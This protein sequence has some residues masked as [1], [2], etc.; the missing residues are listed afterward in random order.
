MPGSP[1][2]IE[3][4]SQDGW[5]CGREGEDDGVLQTPEVGRSRERGGGRKRTYCPARYG[6]GNS[7]TSQKGFCCRP[8]PCAAVASEQPPFPQ[9]AYGSHAAENAQVPVLALAEKGVGYTT[10]PYSP[11]SLC[12]R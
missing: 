4:H 9:L 8:G 6:Q 10:V 7:S 3:M 1:C 2:W 5:A 11:T 12:L